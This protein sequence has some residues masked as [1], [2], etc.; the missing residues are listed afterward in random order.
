MTLFQRFHKEEHKEYTAKHPPKK[1]KVVAEIVHPS[2]KVA[3][4]QATKT[5][6]KYPRNHEKQKQFEKKLLE[7]IV[8]DSSPF[9]VV[10]GPG[11]KAMISSLDDFITIPH[12]RTIGRQLVDQYLLVRN[13]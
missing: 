12:R 9:S 1:N 11:F 4:N 13:V 8:L 2:E 6:A 5:T 10:A 7:F 3:N